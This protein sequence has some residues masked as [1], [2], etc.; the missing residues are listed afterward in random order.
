MPRKLAALGVGVLAL[1][2]GA[3]ASAGSSGVIYQG[4]K[5]GPGAY[6]YVGLTHPSSSFTLDVTT[7]P[8]HLPINVSWSACGI[9]TIHAHS[10][11][12]RVVRCPREATI[13]IL[14]QLDNGPGSPLS[15]D[16]SSVS[17]HISLM[18]PR[19]DAAGA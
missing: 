2:A 8:T 1:I 11:Y 18:S 14:A 3:E 19:G 7:G 6:V 10:P 16:T 13:A 17:G 15:I 4:T 9:V 12:R 5:S